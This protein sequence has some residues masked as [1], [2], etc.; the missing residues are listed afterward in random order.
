VHLSIVRNPARHRR[1]SSPITAVLGTV[2]ASRTDLLLAGLFGLGAL[3]G[4]VVLLVDAL[5]GTPLIGLALL[6]P[7]AVAVG[8][9]RLSRATGGPEIHDRQ[10]DRI[11]AAL[12]AAAAVAL[13]A[14]GAS[15]GAGTLRSVVV[16]TLPLLAI[17]L[18][19]L[20]HGTRRL[21]QQRAVP[22]LLLVAWPVPWSAALH[23]LE[24]TVGR[25][26]LTGAVTALVGAVLVVLLVGPRGATA[27][28]T[29]G[30]AASVIALPAPSPVP[31]RAPS[32]P[33]RELVPLLPR[34]TVH[35]RTGHGAAIHTLP[36]DA[37]GAP[38]TT[39]VR[40]EAA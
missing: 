28:R 34:G 14:A 13:V 9:E 21:W 15:A 1:R 24:S 6:L 3:P 18:I 17:G 26:A 30:A 33:S 2:R 10:L 31:A 40:T 29:V 19:T 39:T 23:S 36:A 35:A 16:L 12:V 4:V 32:S 27:R 11:L 7:G 38:T 20:L 25:P 22:T 8:G 37:T 5:P